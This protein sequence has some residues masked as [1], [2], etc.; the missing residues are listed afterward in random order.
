MEE[1]FTQKINYAE[2]YSVKNY[3]NILEKDY[4]VNYN[5]LYE[6]IDKLQVTP[7]KKRKQAR[8]FEDDHSWWK[9]NNIRFGSNRLNTQ[10]VTTKDRH[11]KKHYY[12]PFSRIYVYTVE[13]SIRR[14]GDKI[15]IKLYRQVKSREINLK[16]FKTS[17]QVHSITYNTVTGNFTTLRIGRVKKAITKT[18]RT[19]SFDLLKVTY[20]N[21]ISKN[22]ASS[23]IIKEY[24]FDS[25]LFKAEVS[26]VFNFIQYE[27]EPFLPSEIFVSHFCQ[28]FVEDK[29]IKVPN[30]YGYLLRNLYPTE[31]YLK[32]NN[33][34]LIISILDSLGIKSKITNKIVHENPL[35]NIT[36]LAETCYLFGDDFPKYIG[37]LHNLAKGITVKSIPSTSRFLILGIKQHNYKAT[38]YEKENMVKILNAVDYNAFSRYISMFYDHY[39]MIEKIRE[40]EIPIEFRSCTIAT[41]N[42]EHGEFSRIINAI[43]K[44]YETVYE[45]HKDMITEL[46]KVIYD[47]YQPVLLKRE[48][49]YKEE[50]GFMHHCV[51][52]YSNNDNSIIVSLR[53]IDGV[54][55]VTSE[56]NAR[57]GE[58]IQSKYFSN[59][60]PP[61]HFLEP[62]DKLKNGIKKLADKNILKSINKTKV[63][64][65]INGVQ[66]KIKEVNEIP[67]RM[68]F[69]N[70]E[71]VDV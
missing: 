21:I 16:F 33:R 15:T 2:I 59:A 36:T 13:R 10:R 27:N 53:T 31:K 26:K 54:E 61:E 39:N 23:K 58:C 11:I 71:F 60:N 3:N 35:I 46:Q 52:S 34:K 47:R 9:S 18:F 62:L 40:A 41:F 22:C 51:G 4:W 68:P 12:N 63:P 65:T 1:I 20:Q 14:H 5:K 45:F 56:F 32:K 30:N 69:D 8:F 37:N 44:G 28:K 38:E 6:N 66:I 19:N 43:N 64:V 55:R 50:G 25:E 57:T 17:F 7:N 70:F 67:E 42:L 29:K 24:N 49:E 48:F